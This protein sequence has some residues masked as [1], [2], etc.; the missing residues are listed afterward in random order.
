MA[1]VASKW[2]PQSPDCA[3]QTYF[4]NHVG[5]SRAP[6]FR[7]APDEDERK[8]E[9]ALS[10]KPGPGYIPVRAVGFEQMAERLKKQALH[11]KGYNARLHEIN[12]SLTLMLQRHDL[13]ISIRAADA[14]RKHQVLSQRCLRLAA[15]VQVLR[16]RGYAMGGDEEDLKKKL[17]DL[18]KNVFDPALGGRS[19]EIW[20]RMVG[21]RER[22]RALQAEMDR[23]GQAHAKAQPEVMDEAVMKKAAKVS[24]HYS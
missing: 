17:M 9:E 5:E 18:E 2:T 20:A 10:R 14:R 4:Y 1:A 7:P 3:F 24:I 12:D 22:G 13:T 15:R 21:V 16:N 6:Y 8:W 11:L 19:E 23:M